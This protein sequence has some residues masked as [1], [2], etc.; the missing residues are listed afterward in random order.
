MK[1]HYACSNC[2]QR[3]I[4]LSQFRSFWLSHFKPVIL[5]VRTVFP[6][7][8]NDRKPSGSAAREDGAL[9]S[10]LHLW[11]GSICPK[12]AYPKWPFLAHFDCPLTIVG[13]FNYFIHI[14]IIFFADLTHHQCEITFFLLLSADVWRQPPRGSVNMNIL[15]VP[16]RIYSESICSIFP[17]LGSPVSG[18]VCNGFAEILSRISSRSCTGFSSI[19]MTG[20]RGLYYLLYIPSTSSICKTKLATFSFGIHQYLLKCGL[21]WLVFNI[22]P[23]VT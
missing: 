12:L 23:I 22:F 13:H 7:I 9:P 1:R 21:T 2:C 5:N 19:H 18:S 11:G 10:D 15:A 17:G 20:M 16:Q 8:Q 6:H 14:R 4:K 3:S